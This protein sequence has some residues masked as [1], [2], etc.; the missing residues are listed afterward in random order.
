MQY[1]F[2]LC[3]ILLDPHLTHHIVLCGVNY[4]ILLFMHVLCIIFVYIWFKHIRCV[5][6]TIYIV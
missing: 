6:P 3:L 5:V 2:M 4:V 1:S